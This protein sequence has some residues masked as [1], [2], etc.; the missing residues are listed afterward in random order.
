MVY[1]CIL[2]GDVLGIAWCAT[3]G[4]RLK[5]SALFSWLEKSADSWS[6]TPSPLTGVD[7]GVAGKQKHDQLL[8]FCVIIHLYY[9]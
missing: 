9:T 8:F 5:E 1:V 4:L 6:F 7:K 3:L 2:P